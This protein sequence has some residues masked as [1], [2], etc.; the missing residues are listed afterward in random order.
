MTA[1]TRLTRRARVLL[2]LVTLVV[3]GCVVA[4]PAID[5]AR[6]ALFVSRIAGL[7]G[8]VGRVAAVTRDAVSTRELTV[9]SR[10]GPVRTRLFAP[11]HG[12]ART[13]VLTAGINALGIDE[14]RLVQM[15]TEIAASGFPVLTPELPD[16]GDYR[17]TTRLPDLV[18]DVALWAA[19]DRSLAPDRKVALVGVSF[20]GGLSIV[21]AGRPALRDRV[22]F[23]LSFGGHGDLART[24]TYLCTGT[25]P[26]NPRH[27]PHDYGVVIILMNVAEDVVPDE[28]VEALRDAVRTFLG[29][30][31]LA[32]FD[33]SRSQEAFARARAAEAALPEPARTVMHYVNTRDV[34]ALGARLAPSAERFPASPALS[35]E[36][37]PAPP[38]PVYLLHGE[39]DSV[40]PAAETLMLARSLRARGT[41]VEA[42]LT[43]L[44]TH[45]EVSPDVTVGETLAVVRFWAGMLGRWPHAAAPR[46]LAE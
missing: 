22:V 43:R 46:P 13:L 24:L 25:H 6:S 23:T 19:S 45:A 7:G 3:A 8:A 12:G 31:H 28:Q 29:A 9:P 42:L 17:I 21:A 41:P 5:L 1:T 34:A 11:A 32:M 30:S 2:A 36:R 16:L 15:A 14:P 20:S 33:T 10:H 38:T 35:P 4:I 40:I 39:S 27:P 18:E 26:G 37:M 44:I